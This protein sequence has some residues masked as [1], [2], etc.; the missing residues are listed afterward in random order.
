MLGSAAICGCGLEVRR[1]DDERVA[2][3]VGA[4]VAHVALDFR[5][6]VWTRVEWNEPRLVHHL[7]PDRDP[8]RRLDDLVGV[9]VDGRRHRTGNS[10]RDTS[11]VE[12]AILRA[13]G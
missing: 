3:E 5:F 12:A 6:E 2:V 1:L 9:A 4:R 7:V 11:I 8:A 10:T 13:V